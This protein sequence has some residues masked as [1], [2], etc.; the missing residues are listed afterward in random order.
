MRLK[1][2]FKL[3][4]ELGSNNYHFLS[5]GKDFL[6]IKSKCLCF[7]FF[8][9]TKYVKT[10]DIQGCKAVNIMLTPVLTCVN[11]LTSVNIWLT[12]MLTKII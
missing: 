8:L 1:D 12:Y 9:L 4:K 6:V 5:M 3:F 2:F 10:I 7:T 11:W